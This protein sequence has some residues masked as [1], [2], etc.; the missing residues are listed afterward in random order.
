[1]STKRLLKLK[2]LRVEKQI[3]QKKIAKELDISER[4]YAE[5]ENGVGSFMLNEAIIIADI[6]GESLETIFG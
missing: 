3:T 2:A 4:S 6:F 5:K 1:M